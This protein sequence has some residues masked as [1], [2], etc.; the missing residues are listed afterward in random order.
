MPEFLHTIIAQDE[1]VV[2]SSV[3]TYDLPVNPLSHVLLTF[4]A[5]NSTGTI[6]DYTYATALLNSVALVEVLYHGSAVVSLSLFDLAIL[7]AK[8]MK[9]SFGQS[10]V[11]AI[12][13]NVRSITVPIPFGRQLFDVNECFPASTR[14]E[15]QLRITYAALQ[16]GLATPVVQIETIELP[17]AAPRGFLKYTTT[18][19]TPS[20]VGYHDVDLPIGNDILGI[21][22][23]SNTVPAGASYNASIGAVNVRINNT[24]SYYG[25]TNWESLH[26]SFMSDIMWV[27]HNHVHS[28]NAAA[29]GTEYNTREPKNLNYFLEK[30]AYLDFDPLRDH[31]FALKT[32]GRS[33]VHLR[34]NQEPAADAIRVIPVE[35]IAAA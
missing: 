12:T 4:K 3:V 22:L 18:S 21:L 2:P 8:Y 20:A 9:R 5:L 33:R 35:F 7:C 27:W 14:G 25:Q 29:T 34:I 26:G 23:F 15:L 32:A 1:T 31:S 13:A 17:D 24:D 19:K 11:D 10:N 16:T 6:T 28:F 30:Y